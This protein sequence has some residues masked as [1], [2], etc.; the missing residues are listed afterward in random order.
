MTIL[1][2]VDGESVPDR[3]CEVGA[4]LAEPREEELVVVHVM[5]SEAFEKRRESGDSD[6]TLLSERLAPDIAYGGRRPRSSESRSQPERYN[7][8]DA[9][10]DAER[11]ARDVVEATL[12]DASAVTCVGRVGEPVEEILGEAD[13]REARYLVIGGRKRTPVGKAV[14]GSYTQ[15]ILLNADRPVMTVMSDE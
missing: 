14:F 8:E 5:D 15:S 6:A 9:Q 4:D 1:A 7:I 12:E 13:R 2:A 3:V 11:V 10:H